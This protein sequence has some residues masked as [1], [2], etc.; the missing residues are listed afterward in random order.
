MF[1]DVQSGHIVAQGTEVVFF[2]R[3]DSAA[4]TCSS[5]SRYAANAATRKAAC[6]GRQRHFIA[7]VAGRRHPGPRFA[8]RATP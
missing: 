2:L 5:S 8:G 7:P 3:T 1:I 6:A 4:S